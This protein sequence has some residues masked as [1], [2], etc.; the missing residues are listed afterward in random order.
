MKP[1]KFHILRRSVFLSAGDFGSL[2]TPAVRARTINYWESGAQQI[3]GEAAELVVALD[4]AA[5]GLS[6]QICETAKSQPV[7]AVLYRSVDEMKADGAYSDGLLHPDVHKAGVARAIEIARS[8]K[9][10]PVTVR[11]Y[12]AE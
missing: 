8:E 2:M 3:P 7:E 6:E 12:S 9:S 11:Y 5:T 10:H 1:A 4:Q